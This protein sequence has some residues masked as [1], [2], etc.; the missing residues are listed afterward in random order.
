MSASAALASV[1]MPPPASAERPATRPHTAKQPIAATTVTTTWPS[2]TLIASRLAWGNSRVTT[3]L[4][5]QADNSHTT[6]PRE[7]Q[8]KLSDVRKLFWPATTYGALAKGRALYT[9][10]P[11]PATRNPLKFLLFSG[12][13]RCAASRRAGGCRSYV[14]QT[15]PRCTAPGPRTRTAAGRRGGPRYVRRRRA[16]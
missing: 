4:L 11:A 10:T 14:V 15:S 16:A 9:P 13:R 3:T 2:T 6:S 1:E 12:E 7:P 8:A 5:M